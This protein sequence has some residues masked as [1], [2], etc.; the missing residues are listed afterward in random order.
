MNPCVEL[1]TPTLRIPPL[2]EFTVTPLTVMLVEYFPQ[3]A[4]GQGFFGYRSRPLWH[5]LESR[6]TLC[7]LFEMSET[8]A[9]GSHPSN[10]VKVVL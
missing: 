2:P 10:R 9:F 8:C 3:S 5:V 1:Q 6:P 7:N 4:F